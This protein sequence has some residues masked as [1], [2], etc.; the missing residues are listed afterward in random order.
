MQLSARIHRKSLTRCWSPQEKRSAAGSFRFLLS[1]PPSIRLLSAAS[2]SRPRNGLVLD[3]LVAY[4]CYKWISGKDALASR[5]ATKESLSFPLSTYLSTFPELSALKQP[6][7]KIID[8]PLTPVD[9]APARQYCAFLFYLPLKPGFSPK[10]AFDIL[11]EGLHRTFVQLPWLSGRILPQTPDTEGYRPGQLVIRHGPVDTNGP[12]PSQLRFN[13]LDSDLS[14]DELREA[15]FPTGTFP[16][17][18][19]R[20]IGFRPDVNTGPDVFMAQANFL[21]GGCILAAGPHHLVSDGAATVTIITLWADHCRALQSD[22]QLHVAPPPPETYDRNA[23]ER[24][25]A[26]HGRKPPGEGVDP[27]KWRLLGRPGPPGPVSDEASGETAA[28][29]TSTAMKSAMKSAIFYVPAAKFEALHRDCADAGPGI[30]GTDALVA[31]AWRSILRARQVAALKE[32]EPM[33]DIGNAESWAGLAVMVDG[34]GYFKSEWLT[35][36]Y[37]GNLTCINLAVLPLAQLTSPP[38]LSL[39]AIARTI[40]EGVNS[41]TTESLMDAYALARGVANYKQLAYADSRLDAAGLLMSPLLG[42]PVSSMSFGDG[43]FGNN[44]SPE[45]MRPPMDWLNGTTRACFFLPILSGRGV[46]ILLN[47]FDE[48]MDLLLADHEFTKYA[49]FLADRC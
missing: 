39:G 31:L 18:S 35:P 28:P 24:M 30:T 9:H 16:D 32:A 1:N 4:S 15:A 48:E 36:N 6:L 19:L 5:N 11:H 8:I 45:A 40:R 17:D 22:A 21:T 38:E 3:L 47:M 14:F 49:M 7:A 33:G 2:E 25:W 27:G 20:W 44:G 37:L 46:E 29:T 26:E 13:E 41:I 12:R 43:V 23:I 42:L 10:Q 34:R